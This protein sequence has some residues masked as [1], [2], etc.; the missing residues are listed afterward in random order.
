MVD[1]QT[2]R[3][4]FAWYENAGKKAHTLQMLFDNACCDID[5]LYQSGQA[6]ELQTLALRMAT[7]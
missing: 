6:F 3:F 5:T 1:A 2:S 7:P 4:K